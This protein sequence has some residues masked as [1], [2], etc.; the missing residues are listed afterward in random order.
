MSVLKIY[1]GTAWTAIIAK[2]WDGAA[3][4]A[5][6]N[7][8]DGVAWITLALI[9][10]TASR[11]PSTLTKNGAN[12]LLTTGACVCTPAGGS[13]PYAF[14]WQHVSGEVL[15]VNSPTSASTTFSHTGTNEA[16]SGRYRC[17]V[18]DNNTDIAFTSTVR[19]NFQH[20]TPQ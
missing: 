5:V 2:V 10:L 8:F 15:V 9:P 13:A 7:Y 6:L 18:T 14:L 20:G 3:W 17:R 16:V 1:D 11:S 4:Q 19:V 12:G